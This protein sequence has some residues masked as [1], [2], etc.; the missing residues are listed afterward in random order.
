VFPTVEWLR[1]HAAVFAALE[2]EV[3]GFDSVLDVG[4]GSSSPAARLRL[5]PNRLV[6]VDLD[7]V[8]ISRSRAAH[9]HDSYVLAD[10]LS[11][12]HCFRPDSFDAVLA[13]DLIEHLPKEQGFEL[14]AAMELVA[15]EKVVVFT[16][17]GYLPQGE[18]YGNPHQR[19]LCGWSVCDFVGLG[20][21]VLGMN[22]WRPLSGEGAEA[23]L[24]PRRL[25]RLAVSLTQPLVVYRPR[26]AFQL[27]AVKEV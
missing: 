7:A 16:P 8:S 2:R 13:L 23:R 22:G 18:K 14:L 5:R 24:R 3:G 12:G 26:W 11:V 4:C 15:R 17:N 20:Y 9:R 10:A 6:G 21:R 19:H 25:G 1:P 27:L